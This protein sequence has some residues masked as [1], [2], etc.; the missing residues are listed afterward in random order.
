MTL[1]KK[2]QQAMQDLLGEEYSAYIESM[3]Q[4][5]QTAIR[6]NT[7]KISLEQWAEICPFETK[8]VPWTEKGFLTTDEQCNPAKHP[9]YYAGLY[10]IQEPSAMIPA[11][12]LP[13]HEGDRILDVCAAPGGKATELAAKLRGTGQLVANDISVSRAMALAKNLQIAGAVNAVVTA[14]KPERLQESFSQYFDG[15]LIDAPCSGEGMFRRDP[16]MVQD[17]EEKGP[18]YYAPIQRHILKAAYQM[19]REGGYLVYSTCTFSPEEDEKNIL[20]FLRQF[21]DMHVCEVPRKEGFC[22]GITDAAL[23]ETERQQLFR[24]VRIFPHKTVGEGHFAVLL[25]SFCRKEI[26]RL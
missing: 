8:P 26:R 22:S 23:T 19:L 13:V 4:R 10:Y 5:S 3:Q 6:I 9:Y 18:Q 25:L 16:H 15:I 1:P 21:P 7:A 17:W 11:S 2:Y 14:E 24:C 12:I 20:W